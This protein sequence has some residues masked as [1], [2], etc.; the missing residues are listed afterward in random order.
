MT[1][2]QPEQA[3]EERQPYEKPVLRSISLVTDQV[4][5]VNCKRSIQNASGSGDPL[6]C[7]NNYCSS[8]QGS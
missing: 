7:V 8:T 4:L 5:G 1:S 6:G 3:P 2:S